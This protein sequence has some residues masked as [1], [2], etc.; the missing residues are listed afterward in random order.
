VTGKWG[1]GTNRESSSLV[2][3][4]LDPVEHGTR[5]YI[6]EQVCQQK[7]YSYTLFLTI[8]V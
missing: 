8:N 2:E 7:R 3:I 5:I 4:I 1:L 6:S